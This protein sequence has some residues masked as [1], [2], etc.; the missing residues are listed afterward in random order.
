MPDA[1][2]SGKVASVEE[3]PDDATRRAGGESDPTAPVLATSGFDEAL[4]DRSRSGTVDGGDIPLVPAAC[5]KPQPVT[6]IKPADA[7]T[8]RLREIEDRFPVIRSFIVID[9]NIQISS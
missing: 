6:A 3:T 5:W 9:F 1:F 7:A 2:N 8:N 4:A